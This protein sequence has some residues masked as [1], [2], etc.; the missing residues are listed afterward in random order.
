DV[1]NMDFDGASTAGRLTNGTLRVRGR[2]D[3]IATESDQGFS[4][5]GAHVVELIGTATQNV[6]LRSADS[7]LTTGCTRSC[8]ATL[9]AIKAPGSGGVRFL[10]SVKALTELTLQA[11]SIAA[12]A[13]GLVSTGRPVFDSPIVRAAS[14]AYRDSLVQNSSA[15]T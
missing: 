4:A 1:V 5:S 2:F 11:D 14:I 9:S 7:S 12:P 13:Y 8:F 3:Q 10:T 15:R 6:W